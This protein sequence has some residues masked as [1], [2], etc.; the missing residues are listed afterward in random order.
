MQEQATVPTFFARVLGLNSWTI[1]AT[2]TASA[3]GGKSVSYNVAILVDTTQS[4]SDTDS[5][6]QCDNTRIHC[7]LTG[8]RTLLG[9]L[10][11][12]PPGLASCGAATNGNVAN[13]LDEVS[14]FVFP[15][16]ASAADASNDYTGSCTM[17]S[18]I[19][20]HNDSP[21]YEIVPLLQRL[22]RFRYGY[23]TD[24]PRA[25]ASDLVHR[26]FLLFF[27]LHLLWTRGAGSRGSAPQ[28]SQGHR[29]IKS[30]AVRAIYLR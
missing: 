24:F 8:V 4:M 19:L 18:G 29:L 28:W 15:G 12:C 11:P 3:R 26:Q 14:L 1:S 5:D 17:P 20:S 9:T 27:H 6:S 22:S 7:A 23:F 16:L 2:A 21:V 13:P 30:S 25:P 10:S